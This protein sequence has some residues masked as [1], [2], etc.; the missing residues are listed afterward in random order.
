MA[1]CIPIS[2]CTYVQERD[3]GSNAD[4]ELYIYATCRDVR[5]ICKYVYVH[6][7][8]WMY[9]HARAVQMPMLSWKYMLGRE[10]PAQIADSADAGENREKDFYAKHQQQICIRI[11]QKKKKVHN[12]SASSQIKH[13]TKK[14]SNL[15]ECTFVK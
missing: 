8:I 6:I 12:V 3:T 10:I 11:Y 1:A 2:G 5:A 13:I 9:I 4:V 15:I 14:R 7:C